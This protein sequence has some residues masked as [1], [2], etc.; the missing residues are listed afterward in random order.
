MS[1]RRGSRITQD[2]INDL[3]FKLE[4]LLPE[5]G[6]RV[7]AP[8]IL[9]E[10]CNYIKKLHREVND[11]AER[12]SELMASMDTSGVDADI[13]FKRSS[14][15]KKKKKGGQLTGYSSRLHLHELCASPSLS[16]LLVK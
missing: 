5:I 4:A 16:L 12:L 15:S 7:S 10:T 3:V 8:K 14:A 2:E 13:H 6:R 11:L 1:S 9:K